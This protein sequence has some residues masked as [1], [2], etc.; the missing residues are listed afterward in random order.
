MTDSLSFSHRRITSD[1][2]DIGDQLAV[3]DTVAEELRMPMKPKSE[4]Q[5]LMT[6]YSHLEDR[7]LAGIEHHMKQSRDNLQQRKLM[8]YIERFN[9][10]GCEFQ[11]TWSE[12]YWQAYEAVRDLKRGETQGLRNRSD[13]Q[14]AREIAE[15][16]DLALGLSRLD[17]GV[18]KDHE[19]RPVLP[20][21]QTL[22]L[23][24]QESREFRENEALRGTQQG[25]KR[26]CQ[27]CCVC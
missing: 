23:I 17:R 7:V 11:E 25:K 4:V 15:V 20:K 6:Q 19:R 3:L 8:A 14:L 13:R 22:L 1:L 27:P 24:D 18:G 21:P 16:Q 2:E 10:V 26:K 5:I 9:Q 12:E